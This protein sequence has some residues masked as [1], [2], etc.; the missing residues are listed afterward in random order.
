MGGDDPQ[1]VELATAPTPVPFGRRVRGGCATHS[2][3]LGGPG[4]EL[5][6]GAH[7]G[8]YAAWGSARGGVTQDQAED[9]AYG[10]EALVSGHGHHGPPWLCATYRPMSSRSSRV[11]TPLVSAH[12]ARCS[13]ASSPTRLGKPALV[14]RVRRCSMRLTRVVRGQPSMAAASA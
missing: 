5:T 10:E 12:S 6:S 9:G 3:A 13:S 11:S 4:D 8:V 2:L 7:D 1:A 14:R